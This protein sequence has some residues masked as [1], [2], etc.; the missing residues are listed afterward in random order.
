MDERV[1]APEPFSESSNR[2]APWLTNILRNG[3]V[4]AVL[5]ALF[6]IGR[7]VETNVD[8]Y[9]VDIIL[10]VGLA[11]TL[12]VSLQL[13]NGISGQFSLGHAGFMAIGAYLAGYAVL[14]HGEYVNADDETFSFANPAAVA[15]YFLSLCIILALGAVLIGLVILVIQSSR[16]IHSTLPLVLTLGL[17]IWIGTDIALAYDEPRPYHV[18]WHVFGWFPAALDFLVSHLAKPEWASLVE[19]DLREPLTLFVSLLGGG[20][21]AAVAGL[22]VG[23]PTLRLKGDYLAIATLGFAQIILVL[24]VNSPALGA[25]TG[26]SVPSY[27]VKP[28]PD[29]EEPGR[30]IIPWMYGAAVVTTVAIWRLKYSPKG[31]ALQAVRDDEIA[32]AAVGIDTTHHKVLAF[33]FGAFF[34]GVAGAL[35]SAYLGYLNVGQFGFMRSVELVV[36][37]TVG[38]L[39]SIPGAI[40]AAVVLTLL[41]DLL[42]MS[43]QADAGWLGLTMT[44]V[45]DQR[46]IVY[47][48]LLILIML[49]RTRGW[50][51]MP[52]ARWPWRRPRPEGVTA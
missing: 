11:I 51:K 9:K 44:W 33:V 13:I 16:R 18:W 37:V 23:L 24:I 4:L 3:A 35:H 7:Y 36:I 22:V 32:A 48:L 19:T 40:I 28:D 21:V 12:G 30:F 14:T 26:L 39:G 2:V 6:P 46:M 52:V 27:G 10:R 45:S 43:R 8:P 34:A 20:I 29:Y 5:A 50:F 41:P 47:S 17:P 25:A 15:G 1:R 49:L 38:G 42:R 31:R